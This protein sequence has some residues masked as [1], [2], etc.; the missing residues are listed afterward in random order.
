MTE[1]QAEQRKWMVKRDEDGCVHLSSSGWAAQVIA[2]VFAAVILSI[3]G[4]WIVTRDGQRSNTAAIEVLRRDFTALADTQASAVRE[5]REDLRRAVD[6]L[7][8]E[9]QQLRVDV[10]ALSREVTRA[11]AEKR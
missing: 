3:G 1:A 2:T 8:G 5:S 10:A 11:L 7:R 4:A 9:M 6:G